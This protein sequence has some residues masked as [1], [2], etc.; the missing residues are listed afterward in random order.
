MAN[1][2]Q[3]LGCTCIKKGLC[4]WCSKLFFFILFAKNEATRP[5]IITYF[6]EKKHLK[7]LE[8]EA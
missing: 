2:K 5:L 6:Y 8:V 7:Q 1:S 3:A 4:E